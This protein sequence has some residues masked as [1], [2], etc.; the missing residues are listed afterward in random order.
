MCVGEQG[1]VTVRSKEQHKV[2]A[3][4]K[5][6]RQVHRGGCEAEHGAVIKAE[7][8]TTASRPLASRDD[9]AHT[10]LQG[11]STPAMPLEG[12]PPSAAACTYREQ[13][14]VEGSGRRV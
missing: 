7:V 2:H 8:A 13:R 5:T 14:A 6:H 12:P 1:C 3:D 9:F 4:I 10:P 11:P